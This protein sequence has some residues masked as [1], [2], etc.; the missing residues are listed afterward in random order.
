MQVEHKKIFGAKNKKHGHPGRGRLFL[1]M[2]RHIRQTTTKKIQS[3]FTQKRLGVRSP[4][5][6]MVLRKLCSFDRPCLRP[7]GPKTL[8]SKKSVNS[9]SPNPKAHGGCANFHAPRHCGGHFSGFQGALGEFDTSTER[10]DGECEGERVQAQ[11][12]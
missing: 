5:F 10:G 6:A 1:E 4:Y 3:R 11:R 8:G 2:K 9:T 7:W 12:F